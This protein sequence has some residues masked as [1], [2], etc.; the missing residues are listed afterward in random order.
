MRPRDAYGHAGPR[1]Y[2]C[3]IASRYAFVDHLVGHIPVERDKRTFDL[4]EYVQ[5]MRLT[6]PGLFEPGTEDEVPAAP[7]TVPGGAEPP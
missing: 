2:G 1:H 4:P 6:A 3:A 5:R 7:R